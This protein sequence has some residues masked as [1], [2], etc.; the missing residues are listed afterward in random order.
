MK[1]LRRHLLGSMLSISTFNLGAA[2]PTE[3][4]E[5]ANT[6]QGRTGGRKKAIRK[7]KML[8]P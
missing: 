3:V 5:T 4:K 1:S 8:L 2:F 6:V 7:K